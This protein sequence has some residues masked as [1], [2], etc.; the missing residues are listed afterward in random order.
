M[1]I[2]LAV[3]ILLLSLMLQVAVVSRLP[4]LQ[5][6]G[7]L[8]LLV[9]IAW[10]LQEKVKA[11]A[12]IWSILAGI[13]VTM[14]SVTPSYTP[15]IVYPVIAGIVLIVKGRIWQAPILA[16]FLSTF[17][18]TLVYH[19]VQILTLQFLTDTPLSW[20]DSL[21]LVTFPSVLLNLFLALPVY[22]IFKDL[23]NLVFMQKS[24]I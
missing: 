7:D 9:I 10:S 5:G 24:E 13:F 19:F 11:G 14:I 20:S 18:G 22:V 21:Y 3:P 16:M 6:T 1:D 2:L 15:L 17:A 4:L 8:M 12:W 23:A